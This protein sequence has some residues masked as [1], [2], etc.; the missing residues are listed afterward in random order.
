VRKSI[1]DE[2]FD[3][4]IVGAESSGGVAASRLS[5]DVDRR[6]LLLDAGPDFPQEAD[7]TPL[8]VVSSEHSWRV[9]GDADEPG[10]GFV[11]HD[12]SSLQCFKV[13][14][15]RCARPSRP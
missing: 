3:T 11:I 8:F 4:I 7:W 15:G 10:A 5:E 9:S 1:S 12:R 6:V 2:H 14:A 13:Q